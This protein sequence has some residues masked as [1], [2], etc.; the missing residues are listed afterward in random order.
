MQ[1]INRGTST[2]T[3]TERTRERDQRRA[4]RPIQPRAS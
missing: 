3:R 2:L 4:G 1:A